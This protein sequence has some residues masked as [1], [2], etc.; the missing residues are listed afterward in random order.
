LFSDENKE[1]KYIRKKVINFC[2]VF[3]IANIAC[4]Y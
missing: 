2:F 3:F 1:G 4:Y